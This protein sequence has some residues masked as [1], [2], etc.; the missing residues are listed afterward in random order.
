LTHELPGVFTM[1]LKAKKQSDPDLP[2]YQEAMRGLHKHHFLQAMT[3][4][5]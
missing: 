4:E 3:D 2:N 5:I 1:A